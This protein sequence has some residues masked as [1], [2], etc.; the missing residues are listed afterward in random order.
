MSDRPRGQRR[1]LRVAGAVF[2][3]GFL[4]AVAVL[5]MASCTTGSANSFTPPEV[6]P[7]SETIKLG[8]LPIA[9]TRI[10]HTI[11]VIT[12]H[13]HGRSKL[14][15]VPAHSDHIR[16]KPHTLPFRVS[17]QTVMVGAGHHLWIAN[18][19]S[20]DAA[21]GEG[22]G[23]LIEFDVHR[24]KVMG[25]T[26]IPARPTTITAIRKSIWIAI[27]GTHLGRGR[28][29]RVD[30][31]DGKVTRTVRGLDFPDVI[32]SGPTAIWAS[33][34]NGD[35]WRVDPRT[36]RVNRFPGYQH[37]EVITKTTMWAISEGIQQRDPRTAKLISQ[38]TPLSCQPSFLVATEAG[39]WVVRCVQVG[40]DPQ[41]EGPPQTAPMLFAYDTDTN[42]VVGPPIPVAWLPLPM[43]GL[44]RRPLFEFGSVWLL[45]HNGV[46]KIDSAALAC[47]L[48]VKCA[49]A[50]AARY[51]TR[52]PLTSNR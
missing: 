22:R 31:S 37:L 30:P 12:N 24:R 33:G 26:P 47:Q 8:G 25:R 46:M 13:H 6:L 52:N 1:S 23:V 43:P 20:P 16:R 29:L 27:E 44:Q 15:A 36:F 4:T 3:R 41:P 51:R 40:P 38:S 19:R 50:K 10:A 18:G 48:T 9:F 2:G 34:V 49:R 39:A 42:R 5:L 35:L 21:P 32:A 14:W 45:S 7:L 17:T 11:W 28:L